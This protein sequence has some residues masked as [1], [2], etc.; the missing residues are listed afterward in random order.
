MAT[1]LAQYFHGAPADK[2]ASILASGV[3]RPNEHGEI[4][5]ARF[6][7]QSCLAHGADR[8]RKASF[9][10]KLTIQVADPDILFTE[11]PGAR[12]TAVIRTDR[13][14]PATITE[15][16]VRWLRGAD[17]KAEL[18]HLRGQRAV[19]DYLTTMN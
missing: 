5:V 18:L 7:W 19:S 11:T 2:L 12:D 13:P 15:L 10:A 3:I 1:R 9:V 16:Y 14:V 6:E 4:F 8:N 17:E